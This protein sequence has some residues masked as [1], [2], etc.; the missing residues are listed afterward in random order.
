MPVVTKGNN[1]RIFTPEGGGSRFGI[2]HLPD[3]RLGVG[4]GLVVQLVHGHQRAGVRVEVDEAVAGGSPGE[5][6]PHDL[7]P[8]H[9]GLAQ[10][11]EPV[12]EE[13]LGHVVRQATNP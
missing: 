5:L 10:R 11:G 8:L 3:R 4:H 9:V 13:L 7:D 6:V 12:L 2:C 1:S